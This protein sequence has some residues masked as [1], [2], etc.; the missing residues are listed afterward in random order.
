MSKNANCRPHGT[1]ILLNLWV[2]NP[3]GSFWSGAGTDGTYLKGL[4]RISFL[5]S[6]ATYRQV[7][8]QHQI[9]R[10]TLTEF[11]LL[12]SRRWAHQRITIIYAPSRLS[13]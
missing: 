6:V 12:E 13:E 10:V 2:T 8:R 11:K 9:K 1:Y 3:K 7:A 5:K 4:L